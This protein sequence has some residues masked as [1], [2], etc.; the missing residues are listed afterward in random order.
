MKKILVWLS[1]LLIG[2]GIAITTPMITAKAANEGN[3]DISALLGDIKDELSEA[4]SQMDEETVKEIFG[5]VQEK[6][7][8]GSLKTESGLEEAIKEGEERFGIEISRDDAQKV[9]E[10]MEKLEDMGFSAEYVMEKAEELYD[11]YGAEFIDHADEVITGAVQD[12]VT[13]AIKSFFHNL[14]ETIKNFFK[15]LLNRL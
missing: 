1:A 13:N 5:F 2:G 15:N 4:V 11:S 3:A 10:T 6:V 12:A 14:W 8:D 9:V 7:Q